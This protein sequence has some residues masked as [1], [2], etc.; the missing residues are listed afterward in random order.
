M[1]CAEAQATTVGWTNNHIISNK[2][3]SGVMATADYKLK[4]ET[5]SKMNPHTKS[6][7]VLP[8]KTYFGKELEEG[9]DRFDRRVVPTLEDLEYSEESDD[10]EELINLKRFQNTIMTE[11]N[12][13]KILS[14]ETEKLDLEA[15]YWISLSFASN[16]GKFAPNL[17]ELSFRRI[18]HFTNP[19]FAEI[20]QHLKKLQ[21]VDLSDCSSLH[22]TALHL[23]LRNN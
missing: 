3:S 12:M 11:E 22:T 20:F 10:P 2:V 6:A 23:M 7:A 5:F 14:D 16:I 21:V 8:Q 9:K 1:N 17:L 13:K 19:T 4:T 15:C 18:T